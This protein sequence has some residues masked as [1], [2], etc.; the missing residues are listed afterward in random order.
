DDVPVPASL[1]ELVV[2]PPDGPKLIAFLKA[3]EFTTLTRRDGEAK[4]IEMSDIPAASV[5]VETVGAHG[6]DMGAGEQ[7]AGTVAA[8]PA[9]REVAE[10]DMATPSALARERARV[11]AEAMFDLDAYVSIRDL[12]TLADW[13]AEATEAGMVAFA[14]H[15]AIADP[16]QADI[17]GF[18]LATR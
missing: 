1:D 12:Q 7:S 9:A 17:V 3:M 16:M 10:A 4:G 8:S 15:A 5:A 11:A 6:P 13:V 2:R 18:S 14:T